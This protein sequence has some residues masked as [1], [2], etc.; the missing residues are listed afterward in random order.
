MDGWM[1]TQNSVR[2]R[3]CNVDLSGICASTQCVRALPLIALQH[4]KYSN[5]IEIM[6]NFY[7][8]LLHIPTMQVLK[9]EKEDYR[10]IPA[11]CTPLLRHKSPRSSHRWYPSVH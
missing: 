8:E 6:F 7:P 5:A 9:G 10:N 4:F 3:M 11:V 2:T 1:D